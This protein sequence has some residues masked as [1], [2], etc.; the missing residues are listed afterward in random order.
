MH[1]YLYAPSFTLSLYFV[2]H[3]AT[4]FLYTGYL[5]SQNEIYNWLSSKLLSKENKSV[6][7][8]KFGI[9]FYKFYSYVFTNFKYII[10]KCFFFQL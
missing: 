5:I 9:C 1:V 7:S 8:Q 2:F 6:Y 3:Q 4:D 10:Y